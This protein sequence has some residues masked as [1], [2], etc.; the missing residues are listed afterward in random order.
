[1]FSST[2]T[3]FPLARARNKQVV[4]TVKFS[5][6]AFTTFYFLKEISSIV[7]FRKMF[8]VVWWP[9]LAFIA[10]EWIVSGVRLWRG[11]ACS[12]INLQMQHSKYFV[13]PQWACI[14][15][16]SVNSASVLNRFTQNL[17]IDVFGMQLFSVQR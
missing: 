11:W 13:D 8:F 15:M 16:C 7:T 3:L 5:L 12:N 2:F 4:G 17:Q 14:L 10:F 6:P 1:M 9:L